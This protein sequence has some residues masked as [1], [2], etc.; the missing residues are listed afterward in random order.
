MTCVTFLLPRSANWGAITWS[1]LKRNFINVAVVTTH[2]VE[3]INWRDIPTPTR[4]KPYQCGSCDY[5]C[6]TAGGLKT[7]SF[8]HTGEKPYQFDFSCTS[9]SDLK[10]HS[11]NHTGE[12]SYQCS[13]CDFSCTRASNLKT[14]SY[15][16]TG[17]K[18]YQCASCDYSCTQAGALKRHSYTHS[19][20]KPY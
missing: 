15:I 16:H 6:T 13:S 11:Y 8:T 12:K 4:E 7:H 18:L 3:L 9:A 17:E 19:G 10:T 5:S 20:E 2:V 14:H 1:T